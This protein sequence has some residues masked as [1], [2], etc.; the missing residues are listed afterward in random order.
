MRESH[1]LNMI[2]TPDHSLQ[3]FA[4]LLS[5]FQNFSDDYVC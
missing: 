4:V 1:V 2:E 5:L 3:E